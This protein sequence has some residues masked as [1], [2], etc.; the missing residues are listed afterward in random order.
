MGAH[1]FR[2][3]RLLLTAVAYGIA[4]N[5]ALALGDRYAASA[6]I[7]LGLVHIMSKFEQDASKPLRRPIVWRVMQALIF[8]AACL[9]IMHTFRMRR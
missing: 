8:T 6:L 7:L 5:L 3:N 9:I 4:V 2:V 1:T